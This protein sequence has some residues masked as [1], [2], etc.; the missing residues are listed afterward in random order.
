[1]SAAA[2]PRR[3]RDDSTDLLDD[4]RALLDELAPR[5]APREVDSVGTELLDRWSEPQ[6]GYHTR[7]HLR[8]VLAA[9]TRLAAS[10]P[11]PGPGATGRGAHPAP[12]DATGSELPGQEW[13]AIARAAAWFH[14]VVYDPREPSGNE[15]AS[16]A[17]AADRL[18]RLGADPRITRAIADLVAA[19]AD[20]TRMPDSPAAQA[21]HDADLWILSASEDRF[22]EYCRQVRQEYAHVPQ[23]AF[24]TGRRAI[25]AALADTPRIYR[26]T[27]AAPWE[28]A[29][30]AN[31][32]RELD[33]LRE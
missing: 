2:P 11:V 22:E 27:A 21:L 29:A 32:T 23:A 17:V 20:H 25:L 28:A 4:W 26:T 13:P 6:R 33:R 8:E 7:Q 3:P 19:T 1:M 31:L 30:R 15:L 24:V 5:A 9:L 18:A 14:D 12:G 16:A 10:A